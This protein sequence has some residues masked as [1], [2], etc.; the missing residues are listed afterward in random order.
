M[1]TS[2]KTFNIKVTGRKIYVNG[3][4]IATITGQRHYI[5]GTYD[6]SDFRIV[7]TGSDYGKLLMEF[8]Y[9]SEIKDYFKGAG[10]WECGYISHLENHE[11]CQLHMLN[12]GHGSTKPGSDKAIEEVNA[13]IEKMAEQGEEGYY[14]KFAKEL[15]EK[16][17]AAREQWLEDEKINAELLAEIDAHNAAILAKEEVQEV[18]EQ[19]TTPD[20]QEDPATYTATM[21]SQTDQGALSI[22]TTTLPSEKFQDLTA[23]QITDA[24]NNIMITEGINHISITQWTAQ[25][26]NTIQFGD[27]P[28][29]PQPPKPAMYGETFSDPSN[30]DAPT[31]VVGQPHPFTGVVVQ[32]P[33]DVHEKFQEDC[34]IQLLNGSP[35]Q[36]IQPLKAKI[37]SLQEGD[38][39]RFAWNGKVHTCQFKLVRHYW[40]GSMMNVKDITFHT[41]RKMKY[42]NNIKLGKINHFEI[43]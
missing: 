37:N 27:M 31:V 35:M 38:K 26:N 28:Q 43:L 23:E 4:L 8:H 3:Q 20:H 30:P 22:R 39:I 11:M 7:R 40:H 6:R 5:N 10:L 15:A 16:N 17:D 32:W 29:S 42:Q 12:S 33:T 21:T 34:F 14:M 9:L 24:I 1:T 13:M 25:G 36:D 2:A 18:A 41:G 19:A